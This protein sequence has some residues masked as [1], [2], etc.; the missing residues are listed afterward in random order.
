MEPLRPTP[1]YRLEE[2]LLLVA[3]LFA[4]GIVVAYFLGH[5]D[6]ILRYAKGFYFYMTGLGA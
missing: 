5:W 6:D 4:L 3:G 2:S 1:D